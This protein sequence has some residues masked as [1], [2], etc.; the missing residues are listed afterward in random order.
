LRQ[1][2]ILSGHGM[3]L[4][5]NHG[6]LE[7]QNGFTHFPQKREHW[8]IFPGEPEQPSRIIL[9]DG[10]G[11]ITLDVLSWLSVQDI[12]LV[13][14]D[15]R[16]H[17]VAAIGFGSIGGDPGLLKIQLTA[18][19]VP[20]KAMKIAAWIVQ[21]KLIRSRDTLA[22]TCPMSPARAAALAQMDCDIPR[23]DLPWVG[24]IVELLGLEGCCAGLYFQAWRDI[25]LVWKGTAKKPIPE[26]W[27]KIGS[28]RSKNK[29]RNRFAR[30]PIQAMLNY[31][32]AVLESQ[33]L[34][35]MARVGLDA[36]IGFLHQTREDRAALLLD[37]IEPLRP[38]ADEAVLRFVGNHV[39]A[40]ADFTLSSDGVCRLHPQLARRI[41]V[42]IGDKPPIRPL[43]ADFLRVLGH[44][45]PKA[46]PHRSKAWLAQKG[47]LSHAIG[48]KQ[49]SLEKSGHS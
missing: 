29:P 48:G 45:P 49:A 7:I 37:L 34:I 33:L 1:P 2:L 47:L 5:I 19:Q 3:R 18:A 41:V 39:F 42:E 20:D 36:S 9:L 24:S 32:Y 17:V 15:Y 21:Q 12:P 46:L 6:A 10:S 11:A 4:R 13:Q 25:P 35:E 16:G 26:A 43:L 31:A 38:F 40:S 14:V 23:L 44:N 30:H 8:R 22:K 27:Y 28:R